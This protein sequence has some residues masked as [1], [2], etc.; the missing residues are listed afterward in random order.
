MPATPIAKAATDLAKAV[1]GTAKP[2]AGEEAAIFDTAA[3]MLAV[4]PFNDV[5]A[6]RSRISTAMREEMRSAG[7]TPIYARLAQLRGSVEDAIT[8]AVEHKAAQNSVQAGLATDAQS[9]RNSDVQGSGLSGV[10]AR[11]VSFG[12]SGPG[13]PVHPEAPE[14][15][16][17]GN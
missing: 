8:G 15:S 13:A 6:L 3:N 2:M 11:K 5:T 4:A 7:Q 1:P 14:A 16:G 9:A 10:P 12:T 17:Q